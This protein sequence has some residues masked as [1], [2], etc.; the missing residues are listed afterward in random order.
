MFKRIG[1]LFMREVSTI[2][3]DRDVFTLIIIV[4]IAYAFIYASLYFYKTEE[5][6]PVA[7]VDVD[8]SEFSQTFIRRMNANKL[9][10]VVTVT[11]D[12]KEAKNLMSSMT[13][14]GI[15]YIPHDAETDLKMKKSVTVTAYLNTTRFLVSNDINKAVNDVAFSFSDETRK[16]F[17][18]SSGY[19]SREAETL[20][21]PV[22]NDI[23]PL[24]NTNETYGDYLLPGLLAL[25][26]HQTL[27]IGLSECVAREREFGTIREMKVTSGGNAFAAITGKALFYFLMFTAYSLFFFAVTFPVFKINLIGSVPLLIFI[28]S[29]L[30]L[31]AI[32]L[33]IFVSSFFKRKF[34]AM[35]IIAFTSYPLFFISGYV[36]PSYALPVPL[37]FLSKLFA[38]TPYLSAYN[39]LT[40]MG[41]GF[42]NIKSEVFSMTIITTVLFALA[43]W[44]VKA[45]FKKEVSS[46]PDKS[47]RKERGS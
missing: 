24:F 4:P 45:L 33:S 39:R 32:F 37:Q 46:Y 10:D 23:R 16:I 20:I 7:V 1:K 19:N 12:L 44:R 31:S 8:R 40:Q 13:V 21:E 22:R 42:E 27:L 18:Q 43:W 15:I 6:V 5:R 38:I 47:G 3:K 30:I 9:L 29:L 25:I 26:L 11:G 41:A 28:T 14:Q 35:I 36:F 17:L 34:V 2:L